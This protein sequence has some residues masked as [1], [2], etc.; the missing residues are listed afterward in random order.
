MRYHGMAWSCPDGSL[1]EKLLHG[2]STN[3]KHSSQSGGLASAH[4]CGVT[5][6]LES[7]GSAPS[8]VVMTFSFH[9]FVAVFVSKYKR[10]EIWIDLLSCLSCILI[11]YH[12]SLRKYRR[13]VSDLLHSKTFNFVS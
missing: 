3:R 6:I 13:S 2:I 10:K 9:A 8:P 7:H 4:S 12:A 5:A 1:T 11:I